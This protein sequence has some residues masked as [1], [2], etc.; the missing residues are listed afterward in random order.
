MACD[1]KLLN[2]NVVLDA[3]AQMGNQ[4]SA[5]QQT[6]KSEYSCLAEVL[7]Y[8]E[9]AAQKVI[10]NKNEL[11]EA[12]DDMKKYQQDSNS[13]GKSEELN[14]VMEEVRS[15]KENCEQQEQQLVKCRDMLCNLQQD[16]RA[17]TKNCDE[18]VS[19]GKLLAT[20][21]QNLVNAII[22]AK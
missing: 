1:V 8:I 13:E 3:T 17:L 5:Y 22:A 4:L 18:L 12:Y 10:E 15:L 2:P 9:E 19:E 6:I 16:V 14:R 20:K 11:I 21:V 7:D